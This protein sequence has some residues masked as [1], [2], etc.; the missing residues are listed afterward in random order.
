MDDSVSPVSG[1]FSVAAYRRPDFRV[2][3]TLAGD[4]AVLGTTL[5]RRRGGEVS[6]RRRARRRPVQWSLAREPVQSAPDAVRERYPGVAVRGRLP[7]EP[8]TTSALYASRFFEKTEALDA[9][10]RLSLALPTTS[11]EDLA[12]SYT[13]EGDVEGASG[14]HIANRASLVVHPASLYVAMSRPPMFVDTKTGANVGIAAVDLSGQAGRRHCRDRVPSARAVGAG[15][16]RACRDGAT[17][18]RREMPS[19]SGRSDVAGERRCRFRS[20]RAAA[21]S[22]ARS[23]ATRR[24]GG[25]APSSPSTRWA[26][27]SRPGASD[28]KRIE[29]TPERKTWKPGE[30]ARI[31]IHSPWPRATAL[32][33]VEREGIRSH[34]RF[35]VTST[36]DTVEVPITEADVPNVYVSVLLVKGTDADGTGR[37]RHRRRP[38]IVPR[39]LHRAD[40]RRFVEAAARGRLRRS[41]GIPAAPARERVGG[42]RCAGREAARGEVTLWAVDYGLL[43]LTDYKTPDVLKRSTCPRRCR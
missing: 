38:A 18:E 28:G 25:R 10:G 13:L 33:T 15:R 12:Y 27:A 16:A 20:A 36:Q 2:D 19:G 34:R 9:D 43:S 26:R 40:R 21:T 5:A 17:W 8:T 22:C 1:S 35:T 39:R 42:G 4:P 3:A 14:Q 23:R 30:T 32:L 7:P 37:R 6:L 11:D 31:L 24:A 41:R 29:L